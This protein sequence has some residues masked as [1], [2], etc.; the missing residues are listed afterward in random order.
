MASSGLEETAQSILIGSIALV[1]VSILLLTFG[2]EIAPEQFALFLFAFASLGFVVRSS[3]DV[4]IGFT[5]ITL[6]I[7]AV[8]A[9]YVLPGFITQPLTPFVDVM[10]LVLGVNVAE[11]DAWKFFV[12]SV[13]VVTIMLALKFR[14]VD[15]RVFPD[16]ITDYVL[17][18]FARYLDRYITIGRLVVLFAFSGLVI[19]LEQTA[20]LTGA[21]GTQMAEV[22]LVVSN[23]TT[24]LA[25]YLSLGG[26]LPVVGTLPLFGELTAAGF[27]VFAL[28]VIGVA[29]AARW[30]SSGPLTQFLRE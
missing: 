2:V 8:L 4:S 28:L 7:I 1:S 25:G 14:I 11:I 10:S 26:T 24:L 9:E 29:A 22:P 5:L 20:Q 27:L 15:K 23:L 6:G 30:S 17:A 16:T 12:L 19:F 18:Q 21:I 3:T 13:A